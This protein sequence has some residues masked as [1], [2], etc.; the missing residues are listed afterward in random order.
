MVEELYTEASGPEAF[1]RGDRIA[2]LLDY[3]WGIFSEELVDDRQELVCR[4]S[5]GGPA[6][7]GVVRLSGL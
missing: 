4:H 2:D 5:H 6:R 1:H 3:D 7:E